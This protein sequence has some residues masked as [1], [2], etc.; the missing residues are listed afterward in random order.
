MCS[1]QMCDSVRNRSRG[2]RTKASDF[3]E[4][5][6]SVALLV[7]ADSKKAQSFEDMATWGVN[8]HRL[9]MDLFSRN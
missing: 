1:W 9:T 4:C 8:I 3:R 6:A 7:L 5:S 2:S